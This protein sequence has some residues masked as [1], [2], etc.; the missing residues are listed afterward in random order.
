MSSY[1]NFFQHLYI[2]G[3]GFDCYHGAQSSYK[4]FRHYLMKT[5]INIVKMMDLYFGPKSLKHTFNS[6]SDYYLESRNR[7]FPKIYENSFT[8]EHLGKGI[9]MEIF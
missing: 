7:R 8:S 1:N 3:N 6:S 2:I 5:D 9:F 4:D